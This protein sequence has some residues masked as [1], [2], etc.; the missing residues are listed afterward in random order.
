MIRRWAQY[1]LN[2]GTSH[3]VRLYVHLTPDET[4]GEAAAQQRLLWEIG[5][6]FKAAF[7]HDWMLAQV[8]SSPGGGFVSADARYP[9]GFLFIYH[10]SIGRK[11]WLDKKQPMITAA[12]EAEVREFFTAR[13]IPMTEY[14]NGEARAII[15]KFNEVNRG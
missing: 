13:S 12:E 14:D 1:R 5:K 2:A 9:E 4:I 10:W 8:L 6:N 15:D 7:P 3:S 11:D